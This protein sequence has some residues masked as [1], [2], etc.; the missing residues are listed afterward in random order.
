MSA[1]PEE[2]VTLTKQIKYV[3][4]AWDDVKLCSRAYMEMKLYGTQTGKNDSVVS[5]SKL[6]QIEQTAYLERILLDSIMGAY[7]EETRLG[8]AVQNM[9]NSSD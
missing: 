6:N 7:A 4:G 8:A 9:V 5:V 3:N 1:T 2:I